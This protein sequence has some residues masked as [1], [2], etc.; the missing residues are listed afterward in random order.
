MM[1][2]FTLTLNRQ[3]HRSI[4]QLHEWNDFEALLDIGKLCLCAREKIL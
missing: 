4:V 2:Q 3:Y 1:K